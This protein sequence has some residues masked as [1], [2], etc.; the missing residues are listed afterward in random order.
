MRGK[1]QLCPGKVL[2]A[3]AAS[4]EALEVN[5][6]ST[7][8]SDRELEPALTSKPDPAPKS[9]MAPIHRKR[10]ERINAET[11]H[12]LMINIKADVLT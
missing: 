2:E 8:I 11:K 3:V 7:L 5:Q 9:T 4:S 12:N 1:V 6:V 10:R